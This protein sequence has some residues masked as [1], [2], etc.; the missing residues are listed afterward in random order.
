VKLLVTG[1]AGYIG[2]V[3]AASR[4]AAAELGWVP[5][6]PSLDD[7]VGSAWAWLQ[8]TSQRQ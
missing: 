1:G 2:G 4:L 7:M 5:G 6:Q 3:V 8:T